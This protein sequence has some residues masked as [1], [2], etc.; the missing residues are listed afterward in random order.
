MTRWLAQGAA[1]CLIGLDPVDRDAVDLPPALDVTIAAIDGVQHGQGHAGVIAIISQT[2]SRHPLV[3]GGRASAP[4]PSAQIHD[5]S[6]E[7]HAGHEAS[8]A[9]H[10]FGFAAG[11]DVSIVAHN[12]NDGIAAFFPSALL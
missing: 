6:L 7:R 4:L 3:P 1:F 2:T 8:G 9:A 11:H 10:V 12:I 5:S